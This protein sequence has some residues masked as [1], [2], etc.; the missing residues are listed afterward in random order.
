MTELASL[1]ESM[2]QGTATHTDRDRLEKLL[3]DPANRAEYLAAT[4]LHSELLWRWHRGRIDV[5]RS[6]RGGQA[7][8][9]GTGAAAATIA[10]TGVRQRFAAAVATTRDVT[11]S[12]LRFLTRPAPFAC[13]VAASVLGAFLV[14]AGVLS[15][16]QSGDPAF[17]AAARQVKP[18]VAR[19]T[20]LHAERWPSARDAW[21]DWD[22]LPKGS[23]IE[24]AAGLVQVTH[25]DGANVVIE[26]PAS[27]QVL[28]PTTGRLIRGRLAARTEHDEPTAPD[29]RSAPAVP[30]GTPL[31]TV[32]TPQRLVH[33]L[34]T[35]FGVEVQESGDTGVHVFEGVVELAAVD[36]AIA[37]NE[38]PF[39][40]EAGESAGIDEAGKVGSG[41]RSLARAFVRSLPKVDGTP[42][43]SFL[44][45]I[46]WNDAAAEVIFRDTFTG[47][48]QLA[49]TTPASR[50]GVGNAPWI[51]PP[52]GW[53]IDPDREAL[54]ANARSSAYL[55]I[56]VEPGYLYRMSVNFDVIDQL[57]IPADWFAFGFTT[58]A[59]PT[60]LFNA[61]PAYAWM[62]QRF[63]PTHG[64]NFVFQGPA[65]KGDRLAI[66]R[67]VGRQMRVI[68][69]DASRP[70]W[71][72]SFL[73]KDTLVGQ[74]RYPQPPTS[75][76]Y[77][78][79]CNIAVSHIS[80]FVVERSR[81]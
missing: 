55:P 77:A 26:G 11:V 21:R 45:K 39:R 10:R 44:E 59:N 43:L 53:A 2:C 63:A 27:Y 48:G 37:E 6:A 38:V 12:W 54:V 32:I 22:A 14:T 61:A 60:Q 75:I 47:S 80:D 19:V 76:A 30:D 49:G 74:L 62:A 78:G 15:I 17:A 18:I 58:E 72:V 68:I 52:T 23:R 81:R 5:I 71:T 46:G 20:G 57:D 4:R 73:L 35:E 41:G 40:L 7:S 69:L 66:D 29:D 31:F 28:S 8:G 3:R 79:L 64:G 56:V 1:I 36:R 34:G 67:A 9:H 25:L 42:E 33:D 65:T 24:V 70:Q 50:G 16:G 51:A 13:L